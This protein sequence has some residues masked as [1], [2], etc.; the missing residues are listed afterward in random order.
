MV[1][2]LEAHQNLHVDNAE[3]TDINRDSWINRQNFT[4]NLVN[5]GPGPSHVTRNPHLQSEGG[6]TEFNSSVRRFCSIATYL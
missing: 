5:D 4:L 6:P 3:F 1:V 2:K